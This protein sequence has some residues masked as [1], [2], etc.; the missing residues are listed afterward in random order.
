MSTSAGRR[1]SSSRSASARAPR[2]A[3]ENHPAIQWAR[4]NPDE[5]IAQASVQRGA[6]DVIL[7]RILR[8]RGADGTPKVLPRTGIDDL[9]ADGAPE[10]FHGF[11]TERG[12]EFAQ[13][14]MRG[15]LYTGRGSFG[16]G[17]Y[18]GVGTQG[19][20]EAQQYTGLAKTGVATKGSGVMRGVILP[21]A[22]VYSV[23]KINRDFARD[24]AAFRRAHPSMTPADRAVYEIAFND[25]GRYAALK[26][27]DAIGDTRHSGSW[28]LIL[29]RSATAT[30]RTLERESRRATRGGRTLNQRIGEA[31]VAGK[32]RLSRAAMRSIIATEEA[33]V[34]AEEAARIDRFRANRDARLARAAAKRR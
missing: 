25:L 15:P 32:G 6:R 33:R 5:A 7:E 21:S 1:G 34:A 2:S 19:R 23:D 28:A 20:L 16:S 26:G 9:V 14:Y 22:K 24:G 8:D 4:A 3:V 17:F 12:Q 10:W 31:V 11:A 30:Q 29:N 27:Y 18:V 13:Q